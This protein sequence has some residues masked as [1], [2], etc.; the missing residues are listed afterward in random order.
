M[1]TTNKI[2]ITVTITT[3]NES[4]GMFTKIEG[5]PQ[6]KLELLATQ[7]IAGAIKK[8]REEF[9][10]WLEQL[11]H[12]SESTDGSAANIKAAVDQPTHY[13]ATPYATKAATK[14]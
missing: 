5:R 13:G 6:D 8:G 2:T 7:C 12:S 10:N 4:F 3:E 1:S 14:N 9:A 11:G